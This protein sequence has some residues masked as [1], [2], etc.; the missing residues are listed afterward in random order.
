MNTTTCDR[1]IIALGLAILVLAV[2]P[3]QT[4]SQS[5]AAPGSAGAHHGNESAKPAKPRSPQ[6]TDSL[7]NP[8]HQPNQ[9]PTPR[10]ALEDRLRSGQMDR[11]VAQDQVSDRL[12]QLHNG[13][14]E[15]SPGEMPT[16]QSIRRNNPE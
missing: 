2:N 15:H 13:S 6:S 12:E 14:A 4:F 7:K 8:P 11:P 10:E 1:W 9:A 3:S 5:G 16:G